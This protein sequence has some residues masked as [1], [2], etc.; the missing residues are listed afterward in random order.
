MNRLTFLWQG[1]KYQDDLLQAYRSFLFTMQSVLLV[2]GTGLSIA[3]I[4]ID[5][6]AKIR[7]IY[8]L[9]ILFTALAIYVVRFMKRLLVSRRDDV[10]YYHNKILQEEKN[11]PQEDQVLTAF[12]IYQKFSKGKSETN[13]LPEITETV[14]KQLIEKE[15]GHTRQLLDTYVTTAFLLTWVAFH[16]VVWSVMVTR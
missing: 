4:A 16:I 3:I 6:V 15:K 12:K 9:L 13:A 14:R 10:N 7:A 2:I 1:A 11:L 8:F 5:D